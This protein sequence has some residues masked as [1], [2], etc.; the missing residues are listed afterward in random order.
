MSKNLK[1]QKIFLKNA[2][3]ERKAWKVRNSKVYK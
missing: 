3:I 1:I 2:K